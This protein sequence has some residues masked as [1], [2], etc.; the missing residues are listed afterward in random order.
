[1]NVGSET[2]TS[3]PEQETNPLVVQFAVELVELAD[4]YDSLDHENGEP[5]GSELQSH[6]HAIRELARSIAKEAW[7]PEATS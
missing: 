4:R 7:L 3:D 6:C 5:G 1:M 2:I